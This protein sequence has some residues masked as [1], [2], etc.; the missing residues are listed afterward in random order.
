MFTKKRG[1]SSL[2]LELENCVSSSTSLALVVWYRR[3]VQSLQ[4]KG[5]RARRDGALAG[6]EVGRPPRGHRRSRRFPPPGRCPLFPSHSS[7]SETL[8]SSLVDSAGSNPTARRRPTCARSAAARAPGA[9]PATL[10][11]S[12]S[13]SSAAAGH[14]PWRRRPL[15]RYRKEG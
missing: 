10:T 14:L 12:G 5:D 15:C 7:P 1:P 6:G 8:Q 13:A 3:T 11:A 4:R 9:E 2:L